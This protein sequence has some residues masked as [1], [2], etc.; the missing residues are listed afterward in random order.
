MNNDQ[1]FV[2]KYTRSQHHEDN[3]LAFRK[4]YFHVK[5]VK[6]QVETQL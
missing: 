5:Y 2:V 4:I 6:R 1:S 3:L